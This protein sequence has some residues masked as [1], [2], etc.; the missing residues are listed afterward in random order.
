M[1]IEYLPDLALI[2]VADSDSMTGE[3]VWCYCSLQLMLSTSRF[4]GPKVIGVVG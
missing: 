3:V 4:P 2:K 1:S